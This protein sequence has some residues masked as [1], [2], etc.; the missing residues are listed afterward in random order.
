MNDGGF[1]MA[2]NRYIILMLCVLGGSIGHIFLKSAANNVKTQS[3]FLMLAFEPFFI[4]GLCLYGVTTLGWVWCLQEMPLNRAY[5]FMALAYVF[6]PLLSWMV[7]G[8][9]PS[10]KY[11]LSALL[12]VSGILILI[13]P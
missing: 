2:I 8:E 12:I 6:V 9:V 4:M 3:S 7:F 10:I 13:K 1:K 5:L 11:L